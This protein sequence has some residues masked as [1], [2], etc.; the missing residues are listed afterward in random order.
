MKIQVN[1]DYFMPKVKERFGGSRRAYH[2][3]SVD[4]ADDVFNIAQE[5]FNSEPWNDDLE[6]DTRR[7][8]RI[9]LTRYI[10]DRIDFTDHTKSYFL[11][12]F[13][14]VYIA[15]QVIGWIVKQI[16]EHYWGDIRAELPKNKN[17]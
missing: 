11:P 12:T 13:V 14:W 1:R 10:K 7:E 4:L 6:L 2:D 16:I 5:W 17:D 3:Q 15:Q 8:M 9:N